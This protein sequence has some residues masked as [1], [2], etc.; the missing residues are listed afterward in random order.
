MSHRVELLPADRPTSELFA[1][2]IANFTAGLNAMLP[3]ERCQRLSV[4]RVLSMAVFLDS[5][6]LNTSSSS[7]S[8]SS[9]SWWITDRLLSLLRPPRQEVVE[10]TVE[11]APSGAVLR[12]RMVRSPVSGWSTVDAAHPVER[13][14]M[15]G[16][17]SHCLAEEEESNR[18]LRKYCLCWDVKGEEE[19]KSSTTTTTTSSA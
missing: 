7:S 13:L 15:Y 10:F 6:P 19:G 5:P 9:S 12:T 17:Q 3:P 2:L 18:V 4:R 8:S 14:N 16:G 11:M 1:G